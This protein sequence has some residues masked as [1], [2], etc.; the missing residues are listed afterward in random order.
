LHFQD[1]FTIITKYYNC[2]STQ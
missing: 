2:S 1:I